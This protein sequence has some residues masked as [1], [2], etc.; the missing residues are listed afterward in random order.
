M[1]FASASS[2]T[3]RPETEVSISLV[4]VIILYIMTIAVSGTVV[5]IDYLQLYSL[6]GS[7][8]QNIISSVSLWHCQHCCE[9]RNII[10]TITVS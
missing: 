5:A 9:Q 3:W 1:G 4:I 6:L 2:F 8:K 7:W 10:L